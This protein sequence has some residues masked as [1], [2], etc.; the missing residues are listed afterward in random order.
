M[1]NEYM[2]NNMLTN[3][4]ELLYCTMSIGEGLLASGAEISRVEDTI[5]RICT[6]FG[7]DRVDVFTI[8]SSIVVTISSKD[9]GVLTQ[10]R[11]IKKTQYNLHRLEKLNQLSRK[12]CSSISPVSTDDIWT[13]LN[14]ID[15]TPGYSFWQM[16]LFY[17][18]ISSSFCIFFG[19]SAPDAIAS[20]IIGILLKLVQKWL[21]KTDINHFIHTFLCSI[22]GG[23]TACL[24][25]KCG[26]GESFELIS[27]G[28]IMLLIPGITMTNSIRDMFSGDMISGLLCFVEA[29][30][31]AIFI[32]LAFVLTSTFL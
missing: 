4:E 6:A 18:L 29:M 11:R 5:C 9:F 32:A 30:L 17:A 25:I 14:E 10:T 28:N 21:D 27:I 1:R 20:A 7:A 8:T 13:E 23:L 12:I 19:G 2:P 24:L 16:M 15:K 3:P 31:L 22:I 26:I